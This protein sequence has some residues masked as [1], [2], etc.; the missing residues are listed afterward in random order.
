MTFEK[1]K[2]G[3]NGISVTDLYVDYK[4]NHLMVV[5]SDGHVQDAGEVPALQSGKS[6]YQIAVKYGFEGT[7]EEYLE[8]LKGDDGE[9]G[10]SITAR[11]DKLTQGEREIGSRITL[12]SSN[13]SA[14]PI[15]PIDLYNGV[16]PTVSV[17]PMSDASGN[18]VTFTYA[19]PY[20]EDDSGKSV[21][22]YVYNGEKGE[23]G[24]DGKVFNLLGQID[25]ISDL[26]ET[27]KNNDAY[28][29]GDGSNK[30][31][32]IQD[33][34][35]ESWKD[36]GA[37]QGAP[38][39]NGKDAVAPTVEL[40]NYDDGQGSTGTKVVVTNY[41]D[42]EPE[43]NPTERI[44]YNGKDGIDGKDGYNPQCTL[45]PNE[46]NPNKLD[47]DVTYK[48]ST[49]GEIKHL[50]YQLTKGVDG[51]SAFITVTQTVNGYVFNVRDANNPTGTDYEITNGI[52]GTSSNITC[53]RNQNDDGYD[54]VI[55]SSN[56]PEGKT[57]TVYDGNTVTITPEPI[58]QTESMPYGLV[59]RTGYRFD[60]VDENGLRSVKL[61][62]GVD[63]TITET[64]VFDDN[65]PEKSLGYILAVQ[66]SS[67]SHDPI[68]IKHGQPV[69][70]T[71]T[72]N[73]T[74]TGYNIEISDV[75][76][77]RSIELKDGEKGDQGYSPTVSTQ[78]IDDGY[79]V[80]ITD[81]NGTQSF[82]LKNGKNGAGGVILSYI[83]GDEPFTADQLSDESDGEPLVPE[84]GFIYQ[85]KT[86][87]SEYDE[88]MY[89]WDGYQYNPI[90]EQT[91]VSLGVDA[92]GNAGYYNDNSFI[93]FYSNQ[94][95]FLPS[96]VKSDEGTYKLNGEEIGYRIYATSFHRLRDDFRAFDGKQDTAW[97][98]TQVND[99]YLQ[100]T[101]DKAFVPQKLAIQVG[102]AF[103][104][105]IYE[106]PT[107]SVVASNNDFETYAQIW[108]KSG[109]SI[110]DLIIKDLSI[111]KAYKAYRIYITG[112]SNGIGITEFQ[113]FQYNQVGVFVGATE[114]SDGTIGYITRPLAGQQKAILFGDGTWSTV[115]LVGSLKENITTGE[116][117]L[118][119]D[120]NNTLEFTIDNP[121]DVATYR[122]EIELSAY[123]NIT[124]FNVTNGN[125][126]GSEISTEEADLQKLWIFYIT[127]VDSSE[128][129]EISANIW[130]TV[131][132]A[133]KKAEYRVY[134]YVKGEV[135]LVPMDEVTSRKEYGTRFY[136][137][138]GE[139]KNV[140]GTLQTFG[141]DPNDDEEVG[142]IIFSKEGF[143]DF[144]AYGWTNYSQPIPAILHKNSAIGFTFS[145]GESDLGNIYSFETINATNNS[146]KVLPDLG[147]EQCIAR[148]QPMVSIYP[149]FDK[150]VT[151]NVT[152]FNNGSRPAQQATG[153]LYITKISKS[154]IPGI[155]RP[156]IDPEMNFLANDG[157]WHNIDSLS[158]TIMTKVDTA[159]EES[160]NEAKSYSD[161]NLQTA[162]DYSDNNL[163]NAQDYSDGNL[164]SAKD[165]SDEN[166]EIAKEF[167]E[168]FWTG[169]GYNTNAM[170]TP[171]FNNVLQERIT[172]VADTDT[173]YTATEECVV[174][175]SM[176]L[177]ENSYI[178]INGVRLTTYDTYYFLNTGDT[179]TINA[180]E[181]SYI[182]YG[183]R[184]NNV[185]GKI[186]QNT[187]IATTDESG[188]IELPI[189]ETNPVHIIAVHG[190]FTDEYN[191]DLFMAIPFID[192]DGKHYANI[193]NGNFSFGDIEVTLTYW[194]MTDYTATVTGMHTKEV[195][196][197]PTDLI[198]ST[199]LEEYPQKY[200][201]DFEYSRDTSFA[202]VTFIK[203][204][205]YN[206][207]MVQT[208]DGYV[209][210]F[211]YSKPMGDLT[212]AVNVYDNAATKVY[213]EY[214][215]KEQ[216]VGQQIDNKLIYR[217]TFTNLDIQL[218]QNDK[219]NAWSPIYALVDNVDTLVNATAYATDNNGIR[220]VMPVTVS[221]DTEN[222]QSI[223]GVDAW[224]ITTLT[225]DYTKQ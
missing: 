19:D 40:L 96:G 198:D 180:A 163:E 17:E 53:T 222:D 160:L 161:T 92:L 52:D 46:D 159:I 194:Y 48:D 175:F 62:N 27:G 77:T 177:N 170:I 212:V 105:E 108:S 8:S 157:G 130:T 178:A 69:V 9:K 206:P 190:H 71:E 224:T 76:G 99:Q 147:K 220:F 186:Y 216:I 179:F 23:K 12:T 100:I 72:R 122:V 89:T 35:T 172:L 13:P 65:D 125:W 36:I 10:D 149:E 167:S 138:D 63:C 127:V 41:V 208:T 173:T 30:T 217:K 185:S 20:S 106:A 187:I 47:L 189:N 29:V 67:G 192:S 32:Y 145:L 207:I 137:N 215:T 33:T 114:E 209:N 28:F 201:L 98:T 146:E 80:T 115:K 156:K 2:N 11:V 91:Q 54:I 162:K 66:D 211:F 184:N 176:I 174:F 221:I 121:S 144:S 131:G 210:I 4:Y 126:T 171:D 128:P 57:I 1:P 181:G 61:W 49:S 165:Y 60:I 110:G 152:I 95:N 43:E 182:V 55:T 50:T 70:L 113:L 103:S 51:T 169:K 56:Y 140:I 38:G 73:E 3:L 42:G 117:T 24:E 21:S 18:I 136:A 87:A 151:I 154:F 31:V 15:E 124:E 6:A 109:C 26:P 74:D 59:T 82:K 78:K 5:F 111:D 143:K 158:G 197:H 199:I 155:V 83:V 153:Y 81:I 93:A 85:I 14:E 68:F 34:V 123:G 188:N 164:E 88:F 200:V 116:T 204:R 118:E 97:G 183:L 202:E 142:S 45:T 84:E 22:I 134:D 191:T 214:S 64:E 90:T 25:T 94:Q 223:R 166:L 135:G 139:W 133:S 86:S 193:T 102:Y 213:N 16:S 205:Y 79:I 195:V 112:A 132:S 37:I 7:E 141:I 150:D 44:I 39:Q 129:I 219:Y 218:S 203:G 58:S 168:K 225:L 75:N 101:L 119:N 107:V 196:I 120:G 148:E 104:S